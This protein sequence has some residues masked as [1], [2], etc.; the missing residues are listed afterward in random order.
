MTPRWL[1]WS[2]LLIPLLMG[3]NTTYVGQGMRVLFWGSVDDA[4]INPAT[5]YH[6]PCQSGKNTRTALDVRANCYVPVGYTLLLQSFHVNASDTLGPGEQCDLAIE[7]S[8]IGSDTVG[9]DISTSAI[10]VGFANT[11]GAGTCLSGAGVIIDGRGEACTRS[12]DPTD[13]N[14]TVTGGGWF[15]VNINQGAGNC[16]ASQSI[17]YMIAGTLSKGA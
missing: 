15:R 6:A 8:S 1:L 14:A 4:A 9:T 2:V 12:L 5:D 11:N 13:A 16:N 10:L 17:D 3:G 7:T